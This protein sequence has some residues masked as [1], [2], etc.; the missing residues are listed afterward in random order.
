MAWLTTGMQ[1]MGTLQFTRDWVLSGVGIWHLAF[2][3]WHLA[4]GIIWHLF[5]INT[6]LVAWIGAAGS[7]VVGVDPCIFDV[8]PS[9]FA[10]TIGTGSHSQSNT[11]PTVPTDS[12]S[13]EYYCV[14][15]CSSS[16]VLATKTNTKKKC[17]RGVH[18][19]NKVEHLK[20]ASLTSLCRFGIFHGISRGL[21]LASVRVGSSP[22][23]PIFHNDHIV[24][25]LA[26]RG[27]NLVATNFRILQIPATPR[28]SHPIRPRRA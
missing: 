27:R 21:V 24:P 19:E 23:P 17:P 18:F 12:L 25:L 11:K 22:K 1:C 13:Q 6:L 8:D 3:I 15:K 10:L 2:G 28:A 16:E 14:S 9:T 7:F 26:A 4:F 20:L 5:H